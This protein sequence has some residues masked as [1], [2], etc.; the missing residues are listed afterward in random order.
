MD[1]ESSQSISLMYT[2][3]STST[4]LTPFRSLTHVSV[5]LVNEIAL[6]INPV[7]ATESISG[8]FFVFVITF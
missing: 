6:Q 3:F 2:I 1:G 7:I 5:D 8:I 4:T